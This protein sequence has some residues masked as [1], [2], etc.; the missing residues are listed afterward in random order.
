VLTLTKGED[1][2]TGLHVFSKSKAP[3]LGVIGV[4]TADATSLLQGAPTSTHR[5]LVVSGIRTTKEEAAC[6]MPQGS[7]VRQ[8]DQVCPPDQLTECVCMW[9]GDEHNTAAASAMLSPEPC[10]C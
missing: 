9:W 2:A 3:L 10:P 5:N 4:W 6:N 1:S 8:R 7:W